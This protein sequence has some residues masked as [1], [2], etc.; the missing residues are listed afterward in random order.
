MHTLDMLEEC[1]MYVTHRLIRWSD[2]FYLFSKPYMEN[3]IY[4][5]YIFIKIIKKRQPPCL[6]TRDIYYTLES[7]LVRCTYF[8]SSPYD[9]DPGGR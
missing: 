8:H 4:G 3:I 9:S 6:V 1:K 7:F 5:Y 2:I